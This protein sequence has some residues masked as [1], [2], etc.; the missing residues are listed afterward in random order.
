MSGARPPDATMAPS[1]STST[2]N[3]ALGDGAPLSPFSGGRGAEDTVIV[4]EVPLT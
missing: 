3:S 2:D 4:V 1:S